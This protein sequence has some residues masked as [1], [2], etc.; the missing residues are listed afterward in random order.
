[1]GQCQGADWQSSVDLTPADVLTHASS[2]TCDLRPV[3]WVIPKGQNSDHARG[4]T[5][6]GPS[7]VAS[8]V[9]AIST[10]ACKKP[11][12]TSD[13]DPPAF[14]I[15]GEVGGGGYHHAPPPTLASPQGGYHWGFRVPLIVFS[16]FPPAAYIKNNRHDFGSIIR[17]I[18]QNF[19]ITEGAL[20]F[21]DQRA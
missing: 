9:N 1:N 11:D 18:E 4:N 17:F 3:S 14:S 20:T 2:P 6:G 21:A 19:G 13:L 7:W 5:G 8:I 12:G 16:A 15:P 10:S